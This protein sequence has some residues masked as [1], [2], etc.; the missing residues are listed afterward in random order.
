MK[1]LNII[2]EDKELLVIDKPSGQYT[3]G[4]DKDKYNS[5]Y[6]EVREYIRKKNQKVFIVNRLDKD[7]SGIVVFAKNEK[8]KKALQDNWNDI[9]KRYYYAI[10]EG[11][12]KEK[13]ATLKNYLQESSTL[14][15]YVVDKTKDAKLA[16]LNYAVINEQSKYSVLD[17]EIKTGRKN[18]IRCQLDHIGNPIIGDKKYSSKVNPINRL[19]LHAYKLILKNPLNKRTYEFS[20][21][22]PKLFD[23]FFQKNNF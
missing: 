1:K 3:I 22:V 2:Y 23:N 14:E 19:G 12:L 8:L 7:T 18:Q 21:K 16:I 13:K 15:V 10:V 9:T 6:H 5:L 11:H 4:T 20:S 17:I